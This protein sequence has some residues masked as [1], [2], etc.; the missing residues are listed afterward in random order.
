MK[1][2]KGKKYTPL[3]LLDGEANSDVE[4]ASKHYKL[5][6]NT[7]SGNSRTRENVAYRGM[8]LDKY[9]ALNSE[10]LSPREAIKLSRLVY[11]RYGVIRHALDTM[12]EFTISDINFI[13]TKKASKEAIMGWANA[14]GL[15]S[16][17]DQVALE[18]YRSGNVY[19][20]RFESSIKDSAVRNLKE[21]FGIG[22]ANIKVPTKYMLIDPCLIDYVNTGVFGN[23]LYQLVIPASEVKQ[24]IQSFRDN[25][26][27]LTELP[28][29]FNEAIKQY[30]GNSRGASSDLVIKINPENLIVLFRKKQPYEAFAMPFLSGVFDDLEFR[31][32]LRNM[33][34]ALAR[35]IARLLIHV[36][37]GDTENIPSPAALE[38]IRNQL[39]NPST[40]TYLITDGSVKISQYFPNIGE[41]L[42]PK[43]YEAVTNDIISA[44][45]ISPAAYGN[46][47]GSFSGN[48]LAIKILIERIIDGRSK[49]LNEFL[50][51]EIKRLSRIFKLKVP[52][53]VE[54][55]GADLSDEKEWA[56]IYNR[57][58]ELGVFSAQ[59]TIEAVRDK[60]VPTYEE[61]VERQV[62]FQKLKEAGL[63]KPNLNT[64]G[65]S[66]NSGR[67]SGTDNPQQSSPK[68]ISEARQY[69]QEEY[70]KTSELVQ[71][72]LKKNCNIKNFSTE[73][74]SI[75]DNL[76]KEFL[77]SN[78]YDSKNLTVFLNKLYE[79]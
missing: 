46:D 75:I 43:K 26:S 4:Q 8:Q 69:T 71:K 68:K 35:V 3:L 14:I 17:L 18:Y 31:Q 59:S 53:E 13:S 24:Y 7:S 25:P 6:A 37:V 73:Q 16:F 2:E 19:V 44:L 47:T 66:Q 58:Y 67:P 29:E 21:L 49:I 65:N 51:P 54:L 74:T 28:E 23:I 57:L 5:A 56:K 79:N 34:K 61:E 12:S 11:Y 63:F 27:K 10:C 40:S 32:E 72:A 78:E 30:I 22:G 48:F 70:I 41:M 62:Q 77:S 55:V 20:Y 45:G 33:D 38:N 1:K 9:G 15:K 52:V 60:R 39:A 50:I 42:D 64:G 36:A 76:C